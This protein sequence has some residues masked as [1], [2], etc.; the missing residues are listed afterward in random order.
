VVALVGQPQL[1]VQ[2]EQ[3]VTTLCLAPSHLLVVVLVAHK[4]LTLETLMLV[5]REVQVAGLQTP[6]DQDW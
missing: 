2:K 4:M 5:V 3:A 1:Q 6:L